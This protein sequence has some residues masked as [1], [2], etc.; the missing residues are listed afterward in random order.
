MRLLRLAR[1]TWDVL[2]VLDSRD[3]C[4]V[5]DF[6]AELDAP[7]RAAKEGM[8]A[9]LHKV[10]PRFGPPHAEP[11]CKPLGLGLFELR[12]QPKGKKLRVVWF[13][14]VGRCIV[15]RTA[16]SKAETTPRTEID[17]SRWQLK[18]FAEANRRGDIEIIE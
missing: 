17:R 18:R 16:F 6:L 2:A 3:R 4:L 9:V 12:K 14:G 11:L 15:C 5:I 13:Y 10:I 1:E 8:L 7:Y